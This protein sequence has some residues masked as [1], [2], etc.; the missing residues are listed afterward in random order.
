M[1]RFVKSMLIAVVCFLVVVLWNF[2]LPRLLPGNP[3]AYL[4]G[5]AEE[6]LTA[7]Q[8]SYYRAALHLDEPGYRQFGYYLKSLVDGTLGYSFKKNTIVSELIMER[9]GATLQISLPAVILSTMIGLLWGLNAGYR[10]NGVLDQISTSLLI[11]LNAVPSFVIALILIIL[12]CFQNRWF[13]YTGL[14]SNGMRP[15]NAGFFADRLWH[16]VLPVFTLTVAAL[17]SR[18][19]L[20]RNTTASAMDAP[21]I[22]YARLRGLD[23]GTIRW[24]YLLKN[25]IQPFL[26]MVGMSVSLCVGGSLVIE[27]VFS[28]NG[29]GKLLTDAVYSLD[30]PLMQGILFVTTAIMTASIIVTDLICLILDPRQRKGEHY[31]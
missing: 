23:A 15:G 19:L 7:S 4:S 16:L 26:T 2:I 24:R 29:M 9:I 13:P 22:L 31:A 21:Y 11:V 8:I 20:M 5:Y 1:K 14:S 30:Y 17:P 10:K 6:D 27:N 28:I 18:Y 12:L 3:I 25:I